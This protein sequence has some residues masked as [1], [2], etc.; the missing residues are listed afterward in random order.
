M[1]REQTAQGDDRTPG[2]RN[3]RLNI[4]GQDEIDE[5][6]G[7]PRFSDE[8]RELYFALT[9][10]EKAALEDLHSAK[11]KIAFILQLG[12]FKARHLFFVFTANDVAVDLNHVAGRYFPGIAEPECSVSKRTRLKHQRL[13]LALCKYKICDDGDRQHLEVKAREAAMVSGKPIYVFRQVLLELEARRLTVPGYSFLQDT[14]GQA[15]IFEQNRLAGFFSTALDLKVAFHT[16]CA[17][18]H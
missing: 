13:I 5:I 6:H 3:R 17:T 2:Y 18:D 11:S 12:Y 4:L 8:E 10:S 16:N 15:L 9:A 14:V 7:L 1:A